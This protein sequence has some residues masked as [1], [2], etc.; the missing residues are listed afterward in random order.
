MKKAIF[1]DFDGVLFDT[2][3]EAFAVSMIASGRYKRISEIDFFS[4]FYNLF[5]KYRYLVSNAWNY[6]FLIKA[7]DEKMSN[8]DISI[9]NK[10]NEF[11]KDA[12][13]DDYKAFEKE[14]FITRGLL[15]ENS[16]TEWLNLNSIFLFT[17]KLKK[18]IEEKKKLFHI[19]TT[20]D[21]G[22]VLKLL[23]TEKIP[24][25]KKNIFGR[26]FFS[27]YKG[28]SVIIEQIMK[29]K[30]IKEAIFLDDLESHLE[31]CKSI[32]N[33]KTVQVSWGYNSLKCEK[34]CEDDMI[35]IIE[36]FLDK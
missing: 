30:D 8:G 23:Q 16:F 25:D 11:I 27:K 15:R 21:E 12:R 29:E 18:I 17:K 34:G 13:V 24:F 1:L 20:K 2:I 22:T 6:F 10:Y 7:I 19:I 3:K 9:I 36:K 14:F 32:K 26:D 35:R 28:K 31:P 5:Q 33:L 4:K